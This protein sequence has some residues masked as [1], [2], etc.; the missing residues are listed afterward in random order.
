MTKK[1]RFMTALRDA[2]KRVGVFLADVAVLLYIAFMTSFCTSLLF[3]GGQGFIGLPWWLAVAAVEAAALWESFGVSVG[4][5]VARVRLVAGDGSTPRF[6]SRLVRFVVWHV[7]G[8]PLIG[9]LAAAD[10]QAWHDRASGLRVVRTQ[11]APRARRPFYAQSWFVAVVWI[12]ITT[13]TA[14]VLVTG[15]NARALFLGAGR[16]GR[17]WAA[18]FQPDWS[19]LGDGVRLLLVT[20]FMAFMATFFGVI[21]AAPLS[22]A[23]ARNLMSGWIGRPIYVVIR[24][25]MSIIR[26]IEPIIWAIIFIVWVKVGAFP[27]VLALFVHSVADLTKLYSER[28]ESI[29]P[30]PV[31]ALRATGAPR[32]QVTLYGIVP[33]IVT[34]FLSF[35]LYRWDI[36]VRMATIIGMVGGGGIG[37]SLYQYTSLWRWN[38]AGLLMLLIVITVWVM[39]YASSR[40]RARLE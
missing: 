28:L 1:P 27:G 23:A 3:R 26:S 30:G 40:L 21:V 39:D 36:N 17:I 11:D 18:L 38:K 4:M 37:E 35:T 24:V 22:F 20:I 31:E 16:T 12:M 7:S 33:Q 10:G 13:V 2:R 5:K 25:V 8:L 34:P 15:V 32:L 6:A 29:D 9:V 14:A 19:I